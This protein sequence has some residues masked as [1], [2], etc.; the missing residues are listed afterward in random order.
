[1]VMASLRVLSWYSPDWTL[2]RI[3]SEFP[4]LC[5]TNKQTVPSLVGYTARPVS[6]SFRWHQYHYLVAVKEIINFY[7]SKMVY[8]LNNLPHVSVTYKYLVLTIYFSMIIF[9]ARNGHLQTQPLIRILKIIVSNAVFFLHLCV[10]NIVVTNYRH[11]IPKRLKS[12]RFTSFAW[13]YWEN[14]LYWAETKIQQI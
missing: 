6:L 9:S 13:A 14:Y 10:R 8:D 1:M 3:L 2:R 5:I 11:K 4:V 7:W 12:G